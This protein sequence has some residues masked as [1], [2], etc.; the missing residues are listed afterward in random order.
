MRPH[1][2][3][4][5]LFALG[6]AVGVFLALIE[7]VLDDVTR[8][9]ELLLDPIDI[10]SPATLFAKLDY[11]RRFQGYKVVLIGDSVI[12]GR[13]LEEHG[14]TDWRRHTLPAVLEEKF[15]QAQPCRPLLVMNLGLNGALPADLERMADLLAPCAPDLVIFDVGLR[16]FSEDFAK[17]ENRLSR[18]W[19]GGMTVDPHGR[20]RE[21]AGTGDLSARLGAMTR[22]LL[23]NHWELYRLREL[24][25]DELLGGSPRTFLEGLRD[26]ANRRLLG[27]AE[28]DEAIVR[29]MQAAERF[30][31]VNL[32]PDNPQRHALERLL[33]GLGRRAQKTLVFYAKENPGQIGNVLNRRRH[34]ELSR[35]LQDLV[36]SHG[37]EHLLFLPPVQELQTRHFLDLIHLNY[38]GNQILADHLWRLLTGEPGV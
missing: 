34:E 30:S 14:D 17:D 20:F 7:V 16:S 23:M 26:R 28:V 12:Y 24:L 25:Q 18:P 3:L 1:T 38:A 19:L 2:F 31:T 27:P 21:Q 33:A 6:L 22:S 29:V 11:L 36:R 32:R 15:R 8:T 13:S 10:Q 4:R 37:G 9:R 5:R 35:E